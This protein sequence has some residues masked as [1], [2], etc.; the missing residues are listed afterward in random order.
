M[1]YFG[2][3]KYNKESF[4]KSCTVKIKILLYT[5]SYI[6]HSPLPVVYEECCEYAEEKLSQ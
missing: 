4:R 3:S 1:F 6:T 5:T 2:Y